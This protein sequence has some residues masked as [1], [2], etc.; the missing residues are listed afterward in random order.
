M[1]STTVV[2]QYFE[3]LNAYDFNGLAGLFS[4]NFT[5]EFRPASIGGMGTPV[6]NGA[7][8]LDWLKNLKNLIISLNVSPIF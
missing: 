8:F 6:R 2:S 1:S 4:G 5:H 7:Q 3:Y